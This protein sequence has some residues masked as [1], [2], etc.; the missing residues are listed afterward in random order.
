MIP[1]VIVVTLLLVAPSCLWAQFSRQE[2][3]EERG[4][5]WSAVEQIKQMPIELS[6][7]L[8]M[9]FEPRGSVTNPTAKDIVLLIKKSRERWESALAAAE[10]D[11]DKA[12][13]A[14]SNSDGQ[15]SSVYR[16]ILRV[17]ISQI[18]IAD[19]DQDMKNAS[20]EVTEKPQ[21]LINRKMSVFTK[22]ARLY[23]LLDTLSR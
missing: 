17:R 4:N 16:A 3:G 20:G 14:G 18:M 12:L 1:R 13:D 22:S 5:L 21:D 6:G 11:E 15:T 7:S 10:A 2:I 9:P 23:G 19:R 8:L